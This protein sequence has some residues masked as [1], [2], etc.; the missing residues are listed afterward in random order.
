M[1]NLLTGKHIDPSHPANPAADRDLVETPLTASAHLAVMRRLLHAATNSNNAE[2]L[3][4]SA[5]IHVEAA[6]VAARTILPVKTAPARIVP[7][8]GDTL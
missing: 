6:K 2:H 1:L 3:L 4:K 8:D 7:R 5:R